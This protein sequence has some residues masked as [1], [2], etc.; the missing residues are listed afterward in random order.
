MRKRSNARSGSAPLGRP[1]L[2]K[3]AIGIALLLITA[4]SVMAITGTVT[5]FYGQTN[6]F[7]IT[8]TG[9]QNQTFYLSLLRYV[10]VENVS[11]NI[12]RNYELKYLNNFSDGSQSK[13]L[14]HASAG[15]EYTNLSIPKSTLL[16]NFTLTI[17]G[18]RVPYFKTINSSFDVQFDSSSGMDSNETHIFRI[19]GTASNSQIV[20][21]T[22]GGSM[23]DAFNTTAAN[24]HAVGLAADEDFFYTLDSDNI[25][26]KV[27]RYTK[28]GAYVD[29]TTI[30]SNGGSD[31]KCNDTHLFILDPVTH[32]VYTYT[33]SFVNTENMTIS[34]MSPIEFEIINNTFWLV[35][36]TSFD[37]VWHTTK[38]LTIIDN[39]YNIS[40][41]NNNPFGITSSDGYIFYIEDRTDDKVYQ[42][43]FPYPNNLTFKNGANTLYAETGELNTLKN[44]QLNYSM[45][46]ECVDSCTVQVGDN[47]ICTLNATSDTAGIT[48]LIILNISYGDNITSNEKLYL[49][50][51]MIWNNTEMQILSHN[52]TLNIT[53]VN[54]ILIDNCNC[55][56][57]TISGNY[58]RV[59]L[60]FH[61]DTDGVLTINLTSANY[62]YGIDNCSND[63]DI[64]SNAT[65]K[66]L[67]FYDSETDNPLSANTNGLL[68]Y[69]S[70]DYSFVMNGRT[71]VSFCV[72]PNWFYSYVS[73]TIYY[74]ADGYGTKSYNL[75]TV[76]FDNATQYLDFY[77]I[78]SSSSNIGSF[79]VQVYDDYSNL[80]S[81]ANVKLQEYFP[82]TQ[83]FVEISQC[84][85]DTN[86][87]CIFD[88]ELNTKFYIAVATATINDQVYTAQ[89]TTT[90]QLVILDGTTIAL[91]LKLIEG[92]T[93]DDLFHLVITPSNTSLIG[94]TSYLTATFNDA[95]NNEHEVCIAY[96]VKNG[97]NEA[98]HSS[99]CVSGSSGIVNVVGGY[100]LDRD[101]SWIA[102]IYVLN[103]DSTKTVYNEYEY[104]ALETSLFD[105]YQIYI[106]PILLMVLL[107]LLALSLY[108]KN[109]AV[110]AIGE[111]IISPATIWI[112]PGLIGGVTM[113]FLMILGVIILY[114]SSKKEEI[115]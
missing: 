10:Y 24:D 103:D 9:N 16:L 49:N 4:L 67:R 2:M 102:K 81:G 65:S 72:Y 51:E 33:K 44:I 98:E 87:E 43:V 25:P 26:R 85:S 15:S 7:N 40:T 104:P 112:Y 38:N 48:N 71:N 88:V 53:K 108:L 109:M 75:N 95:S 89:S 74:W 32:R 107:A 58:C 66:I 56:N 18:S 12:R 93:V 3:C 79:I 90:G 41:T 82:T 52:I 97:P 19:N 45:L 6:P 1:N 63:Y 59:S 42:Y 110:F 14:T 47:C 113:S 77:L 34:G 11:I 99:T 17:A 78:N 68:T 106:K 61:S 27:Y 114:L 83:S 46:Q 62:S 115:S 96:Y 31:I 60:P 29:S 13:N 64:P 73:G 101:Y 54:N 28:A 91:H 100:T 92:Y 36:T 8:L 57:C 80:I 37:K 105:A 21:Y 20:T 84:Y 86:G 94:N 70:N 55:T 69:L 35:D 22:K 23:I 50:G 30:V 39:Y 5:S 111:M 76:L